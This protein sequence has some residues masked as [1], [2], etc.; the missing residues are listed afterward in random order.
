[1]ERRLEN[2]PRPVAFL[3]CVVVPVVTAIVTFIVA[4]LER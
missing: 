2:P 3:I 4:S 1:M